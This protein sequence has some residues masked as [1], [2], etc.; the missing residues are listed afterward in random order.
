MV[1]HFSQVSLLATLQQEK[2]FTKISLEYGHYDDVF[3]PDLAME[4]LKNRYIN[5]YAIELVEG[6][7]SPYGPIYSLGLVELETLKVY[8]KTNLKTGFI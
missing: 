6:K 7:Q 3:F 1:I 2:A 8:I 4:L 5:K